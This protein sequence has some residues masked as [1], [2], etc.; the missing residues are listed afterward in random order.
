MHITLRPASTLNETECTSFTDVEKQTDQ[1]ELVKTEN[2]A[3]K[4]VNGK[5]T[6][7]A[8]ET[9]NGGIENPTYSGSGDN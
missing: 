7:G 3:A 9:T 8:G 5:T 6:P 4:G 1:V 2:Q